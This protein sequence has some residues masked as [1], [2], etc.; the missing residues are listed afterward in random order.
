MASG[1]GHIASLGSSEV[2]YRFEGLLQQ[3]ANADYPIEIEPVG[4]SLAVGLPGGQVFLFDPFG[5]QARVERK[6]LCWP[7]DPSNPA[8]AGTWPMVTR[9]P[10]LLTYQRDRLRVVNLLSG[11]VGGSFPTVLTWQAPPG[12]QLL[13]PPIF[14]PRPVERTAP[15]AADFLL[16]WIVGRGDEEP[17]IYLTELVSSSISTPIVGKVRFAELKI[18][19]PYLGAAIVAV[20]GPHP[21][22]LVASGRSLV[23]AQSPK[24]GELIPGASA[25]DLPELALRGSDRATGATPM[26]AFLPDPTVAEGSLGLAAVACN[27]GNDILMVP[28]ETGVLGVGRHVVTGGG[29]LLGVARYGG[30]DAFL[31]FTA[32]RLKSINRLAESPTVREL[33]GIYRIQWARV[34]GRLFSYTGIQ[35]NNSYCSGI[36]DLSSG[37]ALDGVADP[38][39]EPPRPAVAGRHVFTL[40]WR[41]TRP[42]KLE[43]ALFRRAVQYTDLPL[44]VEDDIPE[45]D[46]GRG[47]S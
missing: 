31:T 16:A 3:T 29:A 20:P 7:I 36:I 9:E 22:F 27:G 21:R 23:M 19:G 2:V 37:A 17:N 6:D 40:G 25:H 47:A 33:S 1:E 26:L 14:L 11:E 28:V 5:K 4:G 38:R 13:A 8:T 32:S 39:C 44:A 30:E 42:Q 10:W 24:H 12:M 46:A 34:V 35:N 15:R 18:N 45:A 43:L 41:G